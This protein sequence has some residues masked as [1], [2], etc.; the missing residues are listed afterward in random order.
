MRAEF[1]PE[2]LAEFRAAAEFYE[3]RQHGLGDRFIAAVESCVARTTAAPS[4]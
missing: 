4:T 3:T 2:A 1:H